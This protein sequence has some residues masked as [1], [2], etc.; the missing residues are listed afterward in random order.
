MNLVLAVVFEAYRRQVS[1]DVEIYSYRHEEALRM[2]F[3]VT[4]R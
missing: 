2:A 3:Q 1:L 4:V